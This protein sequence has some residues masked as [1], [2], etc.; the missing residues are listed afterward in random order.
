M[1]CNYKDYPPNWKTEIRPAIL[2]RDG[3]KCKF[4]QVP[5]RAWICR[6]MWDGVD[7]WQ[8]DDGQIF[9]ADNGED[10]GEAY[11]GEVWS[12][13]DGGLV[14]VILTVAHLDN[15]LS[16]NDYS[17]LAALCQRCHNRHDKGHR[18]KNAAETRRKNKGLQRLF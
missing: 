13:K 2:Q 9:R 1:P 11:V 18:Q 8:N 5:D 12:E 7:V 16:N 14:K 10:F 6:G 17:N 4:C 15:D 3:H